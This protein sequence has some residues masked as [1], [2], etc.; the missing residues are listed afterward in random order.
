MEPTPELID[1]LYREEVAAA[2]RL[3]PSEK[4]LAGLRLFDYA[5]RV[6]LAGIRR[7]HPDASEDRLH[8]ILRERLALARRLENTP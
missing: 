8:E 1:A 2:R 5:C 6:T 3:T 7:Q 4:F